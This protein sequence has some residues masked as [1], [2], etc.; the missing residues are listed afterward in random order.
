MS[1]L[2]TKAGCI[3]RP[4]GLQL[5]FCSYGLLPSPDRIQSSKEPELVVETHHVLSVATNTLEPSYCS[6]T[7]HNKRKKP[8]IQQLVQ[9]S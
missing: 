7:D 8:E 2:H 6:C 1:S 3:R 9:W 4:S 5:S